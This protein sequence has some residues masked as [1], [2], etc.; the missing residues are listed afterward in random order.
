[1]S[2]SNSYAED[3]TLASQN[4]NAFGNGAFEEVDLTQSDWRPYKKRKFRHTKRHQGYT[5]TEER[6]FEPSERM[7]IYKPK[8]VA[9]GETKPMD[10]LILYFHPTEK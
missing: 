6:A 8:K 2:L 4:V 1:M 5:Y 3:L 10:S 9:S 7:I